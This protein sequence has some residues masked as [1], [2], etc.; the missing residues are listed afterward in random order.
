MISCII[1]KAVSKKKIKGY[2]RNFDMVDSNGQIRVRI[3]DR[4]ERS[5]F[6]EVI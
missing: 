1:W 5:H 2:V 3:E 6:A 4:I